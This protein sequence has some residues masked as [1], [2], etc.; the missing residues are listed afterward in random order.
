MPDPR[1]IDALVAE[2]PI[3]FSAPMV[4]ALRENRKTVTRR[5]RGLD[6]INVAPDAWTLD[7]S[8][9]GWFVFTK[10]SEPFGGQPTVTVRSIRCPYGVAGDRL[11]T[12]ETFAHNYCLGH[13]KDGDQRFLHYR[14]DLPDD[15][16]EAMT[17]N[18]AFGLMKF[19]PSIHMPRWASRDTLEVISARPERLSAITE[20]DAKAEGIERVVSFGAYETFVNYGAGL[21]A[22]LLPVDS[23]RSLWDS[24]NGKTLPW[25]KNPWAWRVEFRRLTA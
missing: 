12:R 18:H 6:K 5:T 21:P 1:A 13:R 15:K 4:R 17:A 23:L 22:H 11:W 9:G 16:N 14:A 3:L 7:R 19:K 24:I 8:D 2:H 20:T 10:P 25:S